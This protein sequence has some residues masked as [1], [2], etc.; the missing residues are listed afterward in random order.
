MLKWCAAYTKIPDNSWNLSPV[1]KGNFGYIQY[2]T[3]RA[4][5]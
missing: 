2:N 5:V 4:L 1:F 3:Q